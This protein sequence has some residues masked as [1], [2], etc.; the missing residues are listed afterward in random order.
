MEGL[1]RSTV[2]SSRCWSLA[3]AQWRVLD[4]QMS[5]ATAVCP[6][7]D[8]LDGCRRSKIHRNR[9]VCLATAHW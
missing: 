5:L 2:H 9:C 7:Y 6:S 4:G 3:A 8:S 1:R